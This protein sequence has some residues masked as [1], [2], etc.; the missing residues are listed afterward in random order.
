MV[1]RRLRGELLDGTIPPGTRLLEVEIA[2][3]LSVSRTPVREALHR[4]AGDG[5]IQRTGPNRLVATPAGVDDLGDI[6]L[7]R[8]ELDGLAARLA[9][10]RATRRD[11]D[12]VRALVDRLAEVEA[13]D[14]DALGA[15]HSEVH[16]AIYAVGF[17]PRMALFVDNHVQPSIDL[18]VNVGPSLGAPR[19]VYRDHLALLR[20]LSSGDVERA[21][22]A[23]REHAQSG[24]HT[25]K[26]ANRRNSR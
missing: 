2:Q 25:A 1:Y 7:L 13:D 16:R 24:R 19:A 15:A 6:G 11:W 23:A 9:V 5:F 20:A 22:T 18:V 17:G 3:R 12:H 14:A 26:A 8:V 21:V 4:L 10:E